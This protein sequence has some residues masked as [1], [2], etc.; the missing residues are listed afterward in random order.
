[1]TGKC[2]DSSAIAKTSPW[3]ASELSSQ[4]DQFHPLPTV[5]E[6]AG[7]AINFDGSATEGSTEYSEPT[8]S[9]INSLDTAVEDDQA[10][11][12]FP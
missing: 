8:Y 10:N 6:W 7:Q 1:M 9:S 12:N 3:V 11:D 4:E 2:I 5:F